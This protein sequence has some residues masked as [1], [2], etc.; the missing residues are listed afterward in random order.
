M[1][2]IKWPS[3]EDKY[4]AIGYLAVAGV[5]SSIEATVPRGQ[6]DKFRKEYD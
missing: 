1:A 6:K 5:V 3:E 2:E 4:E